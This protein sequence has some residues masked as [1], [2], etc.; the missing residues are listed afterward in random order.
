MKYSLTQEQV[1]LIHEGLRALTLVIQED[2]DDVRHNT[3]FSLMCEGVATREIELQEKLR[4]I[5]ALQNL[6]I[7]QTQ[8]EESK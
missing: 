2:L 4:A 8:Q 6:F 1:E 3:P 5:T 7:Q